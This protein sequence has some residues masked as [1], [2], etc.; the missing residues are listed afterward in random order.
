MDYKT[1]QPQQSQLLLLL[2]ALPS[3]SKDH[4]SKLSLQ[5]GL[6]HTVDRRVNT[7]SRSSTQARY[8]KPQAIN[9]LRVQKTGSISV[10]KTNSTT[11]QEIPKEMHETPTRE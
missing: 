6:R 4:S 1:I 10:I 5:S 7:Y 2:M 9:E 3:D 8:P 11:L